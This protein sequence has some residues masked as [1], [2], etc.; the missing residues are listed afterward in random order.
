MEDQQEKQVRNTSSMYL[1]LNSLLDP[2]FEVLVLPPEGKVHQKVYRSE[3]CRKTLSPQWKPFRLDV[4]LVG[5]FD[6][7]M[8]VDC[9]DWDEDGTLVSEIARSNM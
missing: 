5:G 3:V 1:K 4:E 8:Q 2:F 6:R 9:Y 7:P